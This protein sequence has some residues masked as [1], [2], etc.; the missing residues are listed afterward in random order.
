ME[1]R[2]EAPPAGGPVTPP[3]PPPPA[4]HLALLEHVGAPFSLVERRSSFCLPPQRGRRQ[5]SSHLRSFLAHRPAAWAASSCL[6]V[7]HREVHED[8]TRGFLSATTCRDSVIPEG[9]SPAQIQGF[10]W[11]KL[12]CDICNSWNFLYWKM[13]E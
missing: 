13:M 5:P 2:Y 11:D 12:K 1:E 3:P 9:T 8:A 6:S 7:R 4:A 10:F